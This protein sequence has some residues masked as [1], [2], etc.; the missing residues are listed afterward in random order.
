MPNVLV[1]GKGNDATVLALSHWAGAGTPDE[2]KA[3]TSTEIAVK[4]LRSPERE[5]Y[6]RGAEA[7]SNNHYDIDGLMGMW[8]VLNPEAALERADLI[9]AVAECGDFERWSGEEATK[10]AC[11]LLGLENSED[12]PVRK[13]LP[14]G[15]DYLQQSAHLYRETLPLVSDVLDHVD[16]YEAFWRDEMREIEESREMFARGEA[17]VQEVAG[18]GTGNR[19]APARGAQPSRSTSAPSARAS[20]S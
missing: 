6:R 4:Y 5:T 7:V 8:A 13:G 9:V 14:S 10:I 19:H 11:A 18:T 1:D 16:G 2:L 12:S 15:G 3:D 17:T 20:R